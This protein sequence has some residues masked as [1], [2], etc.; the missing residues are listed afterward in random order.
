VVLAS[1][2]ETSRNNEPSF[3]EREV[4][5]LLKL[6]IDDYLVESYKHSIIQ[7][8]KNININDSSTIVVFRTRVERPA[9]SVGANRN[10]S[11]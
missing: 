9:F 11:C 2:L 10:T 3:K 1:C 4:G 5:T 6:G 7:S 8:W